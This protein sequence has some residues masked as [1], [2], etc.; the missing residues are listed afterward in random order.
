MFNYDKLVNAIEQS[1][2]TKTYLCQKLG[3]PPYYLRDV[4]KQ[5]NAI[6]SEY[7]N[8][9]AH[10]LGVTVE[11][12]ND[13]VE[14]KEKLPANSQELQLNISADEWKAILGQMSKDQR[15]EIMDI[16]WELS[17]QD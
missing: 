7:Q 17:N 13:S 10:E 4:I 6:P 15:K 1:G 8:I 12:L 11:Y 2:K 14:Q 16:I 3:R 9:L 5:K